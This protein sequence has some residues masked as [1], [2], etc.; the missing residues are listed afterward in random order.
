MVVVVL[1]AAAEMLLELKQ[2]VGWPLDLVQ[3]ALAS[4]V[5]LARAGV[6]AGAGAG[7]GEGAVQLASPALLMPQSLY[8]GP[9]VWRQQPGQARAGEVMRVQAVPLAG[10]ARAAQDQVR[11]GQLLLQGGKVRC[12]LQHA[13][14]GGLRGLLHAAKC[15][16]MLEG[17][18]IAGLAASILSNF[19]PV[20]ATIGQICK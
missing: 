16:E 12:C 11:A 3:L 18:P 14:L 1:K 9:T 7:E 17:V 2:T 6:E 15:E 13:T 19:L 10:V 4:R 5:I 8:R 20:G